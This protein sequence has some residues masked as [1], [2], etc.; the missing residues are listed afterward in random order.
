[1][2]ASAQ[3]VLALAQGRF[4]EAE[5]LIERAAVVGERALSWSAAAS[6]RSQHFILRREQGRL[7]GLE[8]EI[9]TS[10]HEFPS[11]LL[12]R[13]VLSYVCARSEHSAESAAILDELIGHDL[14]GW[15]LDEEWLFSVCLLAETCAIVGDSDRAAGLY[16][17]LL[18]YA[19]L[20]AVAVPEVALDATSRPLGILAAM[21][22]RFE[23]A[24]RHFEEALRMNARM[25]AR[26][27]V[28]HTERE[29]ARMLAARGAPGDRERGLELAGRALEGY[30]DLAMDSYAAEAAGLQRSLEAAPAR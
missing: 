8:P 29:Y 18:P 14:S 27:W 7:E 23:D 15:H 20:H 2:A 4:A 21:M 1:M 25:G 19:S 10:P 13:S 6:R 9:R 5:Q 26:P 12:H 24:A 22:G 16:E 28:A 17:L 3:A 30:R 11:P